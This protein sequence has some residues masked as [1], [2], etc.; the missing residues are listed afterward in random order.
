MKLFS[1]WNRVYSIQLNKFGVRHSYYIDSVP[2][3]GKMETKRQTTVTKQSKSMGRLV[4]FCILDIFVV[5]FFPLLTDI[6]AIDTSHAYAFIR[7][8]CFLKHIIIR[9]ILCC[10]HAVLFASDP[11]RYAECEMCLKEMTA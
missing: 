10:C 7:I 1:F 5:A 9:F 3:I 4:S 11:Q 2:I 8:S 6:F